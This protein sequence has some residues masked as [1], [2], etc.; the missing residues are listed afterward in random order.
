VAVENVV[1]L[2]AES[3]TAPDRSQRCGAKVAW[4]QA[5]LATFP[6]ER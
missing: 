2:A 6:Q 5:C 3:D 4:W 1:D